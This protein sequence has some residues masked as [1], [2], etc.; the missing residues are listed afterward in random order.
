MPLTTYLGSHTLQ[1][2]VTKTDNSGVVSTTPWLELDLTS[3]GNVISLTWE[4]IA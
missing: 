4:L 3:H 2:Q 1:F